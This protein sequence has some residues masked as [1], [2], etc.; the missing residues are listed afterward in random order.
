MYPVTRNEKSPTIM[1]RNMSFLLSVIAIANV[2]DLFYDLTYFY[3]SVSVV[4]TFE[5][6]SYGRKH[7]MRILQ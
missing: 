1:T 6:L 2:P 4:L 5:P 3:V 7:G